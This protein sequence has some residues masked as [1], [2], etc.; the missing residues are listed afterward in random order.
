MLRDCTLHFRVSNPQSLRR[1][2]AKR[3]HIAHSNPQSLRGQ[4]AKRLYIIISQ[5]AAAD[6]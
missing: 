4:R 1:Q 2:P 5:L 3:L 6:M